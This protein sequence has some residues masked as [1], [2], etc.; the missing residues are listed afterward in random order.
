[1]AEPGSAHSHSFHLVDPEDHIS[2]PAL[3]LN[4]C[5]ELPTCV[6]NKLDV[7]AN[8]WSLDCVILHA[9]PCRPP[10]SLSLLPHLTIRRPPS[11]QTLCLTPLLFTLTQPPHPACPSKADLVT[12][13]PESIQWLPSAPGIRFKWP[14]PLQPPESDN[15]LHSPGVPLSPLPPCDSTLQAAAEPLHSVTEPHAPRSRL[16]RGQ[17]F[18]TTALR[19]SWARS[20]LRRGPALCI[21]RC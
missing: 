21:V 10:G 20:F 4:G 1:M 5:S 7:A 11:S 16:F 8:F 2:S 6:C 17:G 15:S 19:M 18:S 14:C 9:V 12:S 3:D 13:L